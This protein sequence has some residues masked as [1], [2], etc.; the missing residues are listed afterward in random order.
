MQ[1]WWILLICVV[2]ITRSHGGILRRNTKR[3][4]VIMERFW[5]LRTIT[6]GRENV[7]GPLQ[8]SGH[9][10]NC[11]QPSSNLN[12][13]WTPQTIDPQKTAS[14]YAEMNAPVDWSSG[15]YSLAAY[16]AGTGQQILSLVDKA[17]C[18]DI[19]KY[20]TGLKCPVKANDH[21]KFVTELRN[22]NRIPTGNYT[23]IAK[24]I[25]QNNQLFACANATF[26]ISEGTTGF[27][28]F[29]KL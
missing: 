13:T 15:S 28:R 24:I 17:S 27:E 2:I 1:L 8:N 10:I 3:D 16:F 4:M 23:V 6:I 5:M 25:N 19:Q 29:L 11:G 21:L 20:A 22:L 7:G 18:G 12:I 9:A 14:L 26:Y